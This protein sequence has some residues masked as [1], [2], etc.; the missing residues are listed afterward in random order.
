MRI[1][2][3]YL[4]LFAA[5]AAATGACSGRDGGDPEGAGQAAQA[6]TGTPFYYLRCN[7]TDWGVDE[8]SRLRPTAD[9][10]VVSLTVSSHVLG[11]H[12]SVTQVIAT[13]PDSW[14]TS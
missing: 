2:T 14:G 7:N 3:W 9:P 4:F 8:G 1:R 6:V 11:D 5:A 12:C 10:Q 13:A